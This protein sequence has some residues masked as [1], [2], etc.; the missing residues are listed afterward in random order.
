[1]KTI[2]VAAAVIIKNKKI[3]IARRKNSLCGNKGWEFPGGKVEP[4]ETFQQ[5]LVR[6]IKEE[7]N[8]VIDVGLFVAEAK[9]KINNKIIH[10]SA[11]EAV[12]LSGNIIPV[13]HEEITFV[14][15]KE[16]LNYNLLPA[17]IPIAKEII[18]DCSENF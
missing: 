18:R 5:C 14:M 12:I 13:E 4:G 9:H 15:P 7:F 1:M 16:L 8:V 2:Q 17:D 11:F 3:L 10:L 6:E